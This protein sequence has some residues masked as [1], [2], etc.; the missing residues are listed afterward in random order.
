MQI[1]GESTVSWEDEGS[2][3]LTQYKA[4]ESYI[5][6]SQNL[7]EADNNLIT[8]DAGTHK[9]PME[10]ALP[11]NLP[12]SFIGKFGN[13]T[14]VVK[15]TLKEDKKFGLSTMITSEPFLVLRHLDI[16]QQH[17]LQMS[18]EEH[19]QKNFSGAL[20][21]CV[22][23]KVTSTFRVN[24]T[25]HLPGED[26]FMD[27]E[28]A[29]QS[30]R[31]V[32]AV[33]ASIIMHST[34][35][36]KN[37]KK[38]NKQVVNKKRDEWEL[39]EGEGRRWKGVRLT[40]PPYIPESRLD[41][42]DIIDIKYDLEFKIDISGKSTLSVTIPITIGTSHSNKHNGERTEG[43]NTDE[44]LTGEIAPNS[45]ISR[46]QSRTHSGFKDLNSNGDTAVHHSQVDIEEY[47]EKTLTFRRPLDYGETRVNPLAAGLGEVESP[48]QPYP[49]TSGKRYKQKPAPEPPKER[50]SAKY[51]RDET[52]PPPPPMR[53]R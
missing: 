2:K 4:S 5:D 45:T 1:N 44:Q 3:H 20:A 8:L 22:R 31:T 15:A 21:F 37:K 26:I 39:T 47:D 9:Y 18:R 51:Y 25:G 10:Y 38:Y 35:H 24:K 33:E 12:S 36:A 14:Y 49:P 32:E 6:V 28:I 48:T 43:E 52:T 53:P 29:N 23:G 46:W 41:G 30:P 19:I 50:H 7:L 27:A 16:S 13:I 17:K 42:C 34:F 40:I 11:T